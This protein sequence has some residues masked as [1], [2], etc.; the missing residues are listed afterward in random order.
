[1]YI[2]T[3]IFTPAK[4]TYVIPCSIKLYLFLFSA[5]LSNREENFANQTLVHH[6][7][8]THPPPFP[9][10]F[11]SPSPSLPPPP[12]P[13]LP[14][15]PSPSLP[16]PPSLS[17]PPSPSLPLPSPTRLWYTLAGDARADPEGQEPALGSHVVPGQRA[18]QLL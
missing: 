17:L 10:L 1:M 15:P 16:L 14:L 5:S 9:S 12:S 4:G 2:Y 13:S 7:Q 6:L 8:V 3:C 18:T 11:P